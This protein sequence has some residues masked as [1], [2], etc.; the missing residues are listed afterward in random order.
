MLI[1]C[2]LIFVIELLLNWWFDSGRRPLLR[3][4][5]MR[6]ILLLTRSLLLPLSLL[7]VEWPLRLLL[8]LHLLLLLLLLLLFHH[9]CALAPVRTRLAVSTWT[10][11]SSS[12]AYSLSPHRPLWDSVC[13][14]PRRLSH[15]LHSD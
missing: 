8:L 10:I 13:V 6:L 3:P 5:S 9:L 12:A 2:Y 15:L 1:L 11:A 4:M 14:R 7:L